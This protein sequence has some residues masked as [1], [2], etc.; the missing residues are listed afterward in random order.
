MRVLD[1][2]PLDACAAARVPGAECTPPDT[3]PKLELADVS[4]ARDLVVVAQGELAE[5]PAEVRAYRGKTLAL[6]GG[7]DAWKA[8]ALTAPPP[9]APG[10]TPA[11]LEAWRRRAGL[12]AAL[13]GREGARR[14]RRPRRAGRR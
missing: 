10:A 6:E 5:V 12:Q 7:F 9:P 2:R 4:P 11:E 14:R 1:L 3:L 13:D 8:Y